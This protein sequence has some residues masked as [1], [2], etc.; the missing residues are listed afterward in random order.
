MRE[1]ARITRRPI[2]LILFHPSGRAALAARHGRELRP[3]EPLAAAVLSPMLA[4]TGWQLTRY[5]DATDQFFAL[6][7]RTDRA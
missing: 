5:D 3:D 4:M 6:A 2:R 1:L 7:E